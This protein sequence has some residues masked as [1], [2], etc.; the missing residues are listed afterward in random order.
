MSP[1]GKYPPP[2]LAGKNK[3]GRTLYKAQLHCYLAA[4]SVGSCSCRGPKMLHFVD[5]N[6]HNYGSSWCNDYRCNVCFHKAASGKGEQVVTNKVAEVKEKIST[7][8]KE[9]LNITAPMK[10]KKEGTLKYD[11][12]K[13]A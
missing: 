5:H 4:G 3:N 10:G 7:K 9:S 6:R 13:S 11:K 12:D 2:V 1:R 8:K